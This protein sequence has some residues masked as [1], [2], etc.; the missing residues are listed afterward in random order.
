MSDDLDDLKA[1]MDAATPAPDAATKAAHLA[2]AQENFA[3]LQG[4]AHATRPI[5]NRPF[6]GLWT[7]M[8]TMLDRMTSRGALTATTA[9]VAIGFVL[10]TPLGDDLLS[11]LHRALS[12]CRKHLL[13]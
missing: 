10:L 1:A 12:L 4:S 8:K 6:S 2:L 5:S 11:P 3:R 13:V 7:G 9:L